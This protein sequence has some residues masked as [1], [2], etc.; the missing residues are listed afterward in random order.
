M[1][2]LKKLFG[3]REHYGEHNNIKIVFQEDSLTIFFL[4]LLE[5]GLD[6]AS[7]NLRWHFD[8]ENWGYPQNQNY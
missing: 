7:I 8:D 3:E 5:F 1:V 2:K 4:F 6:A